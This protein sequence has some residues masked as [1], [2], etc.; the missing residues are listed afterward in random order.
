M[1][2]IENITPVHRDPYKDI[3]IQGDHRIEVDAPVLAFYQVELRGD[4]GQYYRFD[5]EIR[6]SPHGLQVDWYDDLD[7]FLFGLKSREEAN[8]LREALSVRIYATHDHNSD[9]NGT[10]DQ[11]TSTEQ[12]VAPN[13]P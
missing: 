3:I 4:D 8:E 10:H 5:T 6:K 7:E 12:V 2:H 1:T 9:G 13:G 11:T